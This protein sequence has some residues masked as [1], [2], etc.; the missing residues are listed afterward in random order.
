MNMTA[1]I[2]TDNTALDRS[3][4]MIL[5]LHLSD[6]IFGLPVA[7]VH[8]IID[9]MPITLVPNAPAHAPGLINVRGAVVPVFGLR[10]RLRIPDAPPSDTARIVVIETE[11]DGAPMRLAILADAV[12]EVIDVDMASLEPVPDLG[13]PWPETYVA[14]VL[15]HN[16]ALVVLLNTDNLFRP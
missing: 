7:M 2:Q 4:D 14:G 3:T 1:N 15:R 10:N 5:T 6:E 16:A 13:A 12:D 9:P 8:E 11:H